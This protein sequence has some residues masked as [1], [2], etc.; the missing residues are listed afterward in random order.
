MSVPGWQYCGRRSGDFWRASGLGQERLG[1]RSGA[2]A[3]ELGRRADAALAFGVQFTYSV[4]LIWFQVWRGGGECSRLGRPAGFSAW[5][6]YDLAIRVGQAWAWSSARVY[7]L[8]DGAALRSESSSWPG[9]DGR[10]LQ[11]CE[12]LDGRVVERA[13]YRLA[14]REALRSE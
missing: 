13:Q 8:A 3:A 7:R 11:A 5:T 6:A 4:T 9:R 10:A 12:R 14:G 1:S 2:D